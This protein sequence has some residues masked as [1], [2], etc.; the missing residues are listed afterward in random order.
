MN[1]PMRYLGEQLVTEP[2]SERVLEFLSGDGSDVA[3]PALHDGGMLL[4]AD[5]TYLVEVLW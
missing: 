4:R 2:R 1:A 5:Q 3:V